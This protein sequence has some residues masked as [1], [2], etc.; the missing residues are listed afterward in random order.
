MAST[1]E[2]R[3]VTDFFGTFE[4]A[5]ETLD[6]DAL[7]MCFADTFMAADPSGA[8][9]VPRQAFLSVLPRRKEMFA[10]AGIARVWLSGLNHRSLDENYI[11]AQTEWT[12]ERQD[13]SAG[14]SAVTLLSSFVLRR[15]EDGLRIVFYLNHRDLAEVLAPDSNRPAETDL[16]TSRPNRRGG[17]EGATIEQAAT[18]TA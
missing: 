9:P 1:T 14:Q 4:R 8:Q 16:A 12:A 18:P 13:G 7:V 11:L 5:S 2:D 3:E 6:P 15:T 17:P 10:A